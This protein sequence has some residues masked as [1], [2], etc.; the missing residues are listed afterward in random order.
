[1]NHRAAEVVRLLEDYR[2]LAHPEF[3]REPTEPVNASRSFESNRP[4]KRP[5]ED[6][7]QDDVE[8]NEAYGD[9][10]SFPSSSKLILVY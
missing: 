7:A 9:V 10:C 6:T 4:P 2:R 5:W 8:G 3:E 1:M